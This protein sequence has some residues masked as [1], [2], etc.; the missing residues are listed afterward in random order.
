MVCRNYRGL[1]NSNSSTARD[2][3][4]KYR[5]TYL[6]YLVLNALDVSD[7]GLLQ[8]QVGVSPDA[9]RFG[10]VPL[11]LLCRGGRRRRWRRRRYKQRRS[12]LR[13]YRLDGRPRRRRRWRG[14]IRLVRWTQ[15]AGPRP[16][17]LIATARSQGTYARVGTIVW[18]AKKAGWGFWVEFHPAVGRGWHQW[19]VIVTYRQIKFVASRVNSTPFAAFSVAYFRYLSYFKIWTRDECFVRKTD[20]NK[21]Y[22][23]RHKSIKYT[24]IFIVLFNTYNFLCNILNKKDLNTLAF[25]LV[26]SSILEKVVPKFSH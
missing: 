18:K 15:G 13:W 8:Q 7:V 17:P 21:K 25:V 12:V 22:K 1:E 11:L 20:K 9:H 4:E 3:K 24:Y 14:V 19:S 10:V 26:F 16:R 2:I 23:T 6:T 5:N